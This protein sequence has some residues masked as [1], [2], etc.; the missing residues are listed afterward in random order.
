MWVVCRWK[1]DSGLFITS[2]KSRESMINTLLELGQEIESTVVKEFDTY[3]E[4]MKYKK[5]I[6]GANDLIEQ[7]KN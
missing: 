7:I 2:R 1:D 6:G 3:D 4:A 5:E